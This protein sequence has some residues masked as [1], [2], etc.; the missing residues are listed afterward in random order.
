MGVS[1]LITI[2]YTVGS[3]AFI[4]MRMC[5]LKSRGC[6]SDFC[7]LPQTIKVQFGSLFM[8]KFYVRFSWVLA[9]T[10]SS[11]RFSRI[12][13]STWRTLD[14]PSRTSNE[15]MS[16][17]LPILILPWVLCCF[18]SDCH[19]RFSFLT[20]ILQSIREPL[21]LLIQIWSQVE[22]RL[23]LNLKEHRS[24]LQPQLRSVNNSLSTSIFNNSVTLASISQ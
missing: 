14:T 11:W 23:K 19:Q 17:I 6:T 16:Y 3:K 22:L 24:L 20:L 5:P 15:A 12:Y 21:K 7:L 2:Q 13:P 8:K 1:F 4:T 18:V 9:P 10:S